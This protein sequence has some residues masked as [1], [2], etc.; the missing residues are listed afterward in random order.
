MRAPHTATNGMQIVFGWLVAQEARLHRQL[1]LM[2][3]RRALHRAFT[4]FA[5]A[6]QQ[7]AESLFDAHFVETRVA[8]LVLR[9]IETGA[10]VRA[11]TIAT[12]WFVACRGLQAS[13][14]GH[15]LST[16]TAAAC[17]L[18]ACLE[19]ELRP[20][21]AGED[22]PDADC[23]ALFAEAVRDNSNLELDWLW[24]ATQVRDDERRR[25]CYAK[26]LHINPACEEARRAL[27]TLTP[28]LIP[29]RDLAFGE[30]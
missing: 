15:D 12:A 6:N 19:A 3:V 4:R 20:A 16:V 18:L 10:P 28:A 21:G 14:A 25:F 13:A 1:Q 7:L 23:A 9:A 24:L 30:A 26:A 8:P 27:A 22:E 29:A 17:E 5:A 11:E 2:S